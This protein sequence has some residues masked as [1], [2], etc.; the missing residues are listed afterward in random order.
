M[1]K[2]IAVAL[3]V[4]VLCVAAV[5]AGA[6]YS[7]ELSWDMF[8]ESPGYEFGPEAYDAYVK[9]YDAY[10]AARAEQAAAAVAANGSVAPDFD[11]IEEEYAKVDWSRIEPDILEEAGPG[12]FGYDEYI[13]R[14]R[15]N[16]AAQAEQ[17]AR[18]VAAN[19]HPP[20]DYDK[21][22]EEYAKIDWSRIE[23]D[24]LIDAS[25]RGDNIPTQS[26]TLP[27]TAMA[28]GVVSHTWT[29]YYFMGYDY[30]KT[31]FSGTVSTG[32]M[33]VSIMLYDMSAGSYVGT[34]PLGYAS[35]WDSIENHWYDLAPG[36]L[37]CFRIQVESRYPANSGST[38]AISMNIYG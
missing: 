20:P 24:I 35:S 33:Q 13:A 9:A 28:S 3:A 32:T 37:Y 11:K 6:A 1:K 25:A 17:A 7:G 5:S 10:A 29:N 2:L 21:I 26:T 19:G 8:Y 14:Y 15:A 18:A 16:E 30:F 22:E 36:H 34:Q 12:G 38:L 27:Y 31:V 23:P 4:C